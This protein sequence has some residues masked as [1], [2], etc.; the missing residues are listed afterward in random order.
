MRRRA[1]LAHLEFEG[2]GFLYKMVRLLTGSLVRCAQGRAR[3]S[4][5]PACWPAARKIELRGA[6]PTGLY[7]LRVLYRR[8]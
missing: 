4:G 7:L 3:R 8:T 6:R 2:D 1:A 5:S